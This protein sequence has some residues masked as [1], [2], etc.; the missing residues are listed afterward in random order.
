MSKSNFNS[1]NVKSS[2]INSG[3]FSSARFPDPSKNTWSCLWQNCTAK[4]DTDIDTY[5]HLFTA[6]AKKGRQVCLWE[7]NSKKKEPCNTTIT[8]KGDFKHHAVVHFSHDFKPLT[9]PFCPKKIRNRQELHLHKKTHQI[10]NSKIDTNIPRTIDNTPTSSSPQS[11]LIQST[12]SQV[13]ASP[14]EFLS[15][16]SLP[17]SLPQDTNNFEFRNNSGETSFSTY[18]NETEAAH[19]K[20]S[21]LLLPHQLLDNNQYTPFLQYNNPDTHYTNSNVINSPTNLFERLKFIDRSDVASSASDTFELTDLSNREAPLHQLHALNDRNVMCN[22]P[23]LASPIENQW[24]YDSLQP[25]SELLE[26]YNNPLPSMNYSDL[27]ASAY[28]RTDNSLNFMSPSESNF[29][30]TTTNALLISTL[31]EM[32]SPFSSGSSSSQS[33]QPRVNTTRRYSTSTLA[34]ENNTDEEKQ[35]E[36]IINNMVI[37]P[38]YHVFD[39]KTSFSKIIII[40]EKNFNFFDKIISEELPSNSKEKLKNNYNTTFTDEYT[41]IAAQDLKKINIDT[42][43]TLKNTKIPSK[44]FIVNREMRVSYNIGYNVCIFWNSVEMLSKQLKRPIPIEFRDKV[45]EIFQR[46]GIFGRLPPNFVLRLQGLFFRSSSDLAIIKKREM[47]K[48]SMSE[49]LNYMI[50]FLNNSIENTLIKEINFELDNLNQQGKFL[51]KNET[52]FP[53]FYENPPV[54][55]ILLLISK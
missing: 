48:K 40:S 21:S 46:D 12:D 11:T 53:M 17:D 6:H 43:H 42:I 4:F 30:L 52:F 20:L 51:E 29:F 8:H 7:A 47:A 41:P 39:E 38:S 25:Q 54:K 14:A 55:I 45:I 32:D 23:V 19:Q 15:Q 24:T 28:S 10:F 44:F 49:R 22:N 2:S 31:K 50:T 5:N 34:Q 1:S 33:F 13:F 36:V 16:L 9:C 26:P 3:S 35:D 37:L 18:S 27:M